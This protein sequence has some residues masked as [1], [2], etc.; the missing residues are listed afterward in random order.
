[1]LPNAAFADPITDSPLAYHDFLNTSK[2]PEK[3]SL[4]FPASSLNPSEI[5]T[6]S[7]IVPGAPPEP[8]CPPFFW[9][10]FI[11]SNGLRYPSSASFAPSRADV[12]YSMAFVHV[13]CS[14]I[15]AVSYPNESARRVMYSM[16]F[17]AAQIWKAF[18]PSLPI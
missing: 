11:S 2:I 8:D 12:V 15:A 6:S 18:V 14:V 3:I 9:Y 1:M 17:M 5:G 4:A 10:L 7:N 13:F 16:A